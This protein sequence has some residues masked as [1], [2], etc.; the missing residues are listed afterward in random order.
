MESG[1][2]GTI[3]IFPLLADYNMDCRRKPRI[4]DKLFTTLDREPF[5]KYVEAKHFCANGRDNEILGNAIKCRKK[6]MDCTVCQNFSVYKL[7]SI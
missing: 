3:S 5:K 2:W 4:S 7:V 6:Y 1:A